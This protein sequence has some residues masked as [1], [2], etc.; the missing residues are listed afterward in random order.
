MLRFVR[1]RAL[2][3]SSLIQPAL[4]MALYGAAMSGN[5]NRLSMGMPAPDGAYVVSYLTFMAA[6]VI[7]LTTLFTSIFGGVT[8]LFD[9]NW[10]LM[11]EMM[12]S[13]MPRAH[14]ILGIGLSGVTKSFIQSVIIM[15][16]G[17]AIGVRFFS[18]YSLV[19]TL[20]AVLGILVFVAVFAL[21]FL[22]LSSAISMSMDS[23]EGVQGVIT[24]LTLPLFFASNALY[25]TN[26]LPSPIRVASM[27]NPL[28]HLISGIRYFAIGKD[29]YAL[30]I[31]YLYT[32]QEIF[33]SFAALLFFA[34]IMF[35]WAWW[36]FKRAVVT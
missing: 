19:Q 33:V 2:L 26:G 6:G 27:I 5:F 32:S 17:L 11:R 15:G 13:P 29:F 18:G 21:G 34:L 12:A 35:T 4:W 36:V 23:H 28:T 22:F 30:G 25:P 8:L 1:F 16:F 24:L 10:G 31:H 14:I 7:A 9:K 3:F 20:L